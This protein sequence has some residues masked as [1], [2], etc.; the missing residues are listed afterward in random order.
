MTLSDLILT[1]GEY[2]PFTVLRIKFKGSSLKPLCLP[3][4]HALIDYGECKVE[5]FSGS[6][7]ILR[8]GKHEKK[9]KNSTGG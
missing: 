9:K 5:I 6:D 8:G 7:I 1:N 4:V 3:L 2:G